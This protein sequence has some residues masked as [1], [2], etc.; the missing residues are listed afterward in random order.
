MKILSLEQ[1]RQADKITIEKEDIN[2]INLMERAGGYAFQWI[3]QRLQ[4]GPVPIKV[5]C[6]IGNNGGDGLVIARY[7][8]ENNYHVTTY[9]VN[10]SDKRSEDFLKAYDSLKNATKNWPIT[11]REGDDLPEID[12]RDLVI[13]AVFGIGLNRPAPQW[14]QNLYKKIN[15]SQA[16]IL[17]ID[18]PSGL[19]MDKAPAKNEEIIHATTVLT[20]QVP[21]LVFFLPETGK[22]FNGWE[23]L[24]IGLDRE[25]LATAKS[26]TL[27][28][29]KEHAVQLYRPRPKF[30]HK[31]I[32]GHTVIAGGS[33]GK[34]GS[35]AMSTKA[36]LR[37]GAGL[38]TAYIPQLGVDILQT[39]IPEAMVEADRQNGKFIEEFD[40]DADADIIG[41]GMGMGTDDATAKAFGEF[42]Q[43]N[44]EPLVIDADGLNILAKNPKFLEFLPEKTILT[45]HPKE[46]ERLIGEWE[47]DFD[48]LK[49]AQ[50]FAK[51]YKLILLI[52]GAYTFI[53]HEDMMYIN[54]S[55]NPGMATAGA[56][57]VLTGILT[58][59]RAQKYDALDA[60]I[61][62]VYLHGSA[63]DIASSKLGYESVIAGDIIENIS[64][65]FKELFAQPQQNPQEQGQRR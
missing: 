3:H 51:K 9:V 15:A 5:F 19:Y 41:V 6:G 45:P 37:T 54:T 61:F 20:F 30:S 16:Y 43:E 29:G 25:Y 17:S 39:A 47:D 42:L 28:I 46:L 33:Y 34:M 57:D 24:D 23:I 21:K 40:I 58:G 50:A 56:G 11:L 48:K 10:Y 55:G 32:F 38:V 62:G 65:A 59:L 49:K 1:L 4:N 12:E 63:G 18:M 27:L 52:K 13:D 31:G 14:V 44:D 60:A 22:M 7:L 53:I 8:I 36:A 35:V 2:S 64:E 26:N